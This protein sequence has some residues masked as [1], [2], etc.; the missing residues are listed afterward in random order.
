MLRLAMLLGLVFLGS[1]INSFSQQGQNSAKSQPPCAQPESRQFDF[2]IGEWNAAW[3][4][5]G[6]PGKGT[7]TI[8]SVLGNCVIEEN[9]DGTPKIEYSRK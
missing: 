5:E 4:L 2:W 8:R 3:E 6:K 7:N 1:S 9:F